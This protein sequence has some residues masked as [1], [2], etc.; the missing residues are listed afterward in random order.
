VTLAWRVTLTVFAVAEF[1]A[2]MTNDLV[3]QP[4]IWRF[5]AGAL[6]FCLSVAA[7]I[8]TL[9]GPF[10]V[11]FL[12]VRRQWPP[13]ASFTLS[14]TADGPAFVVP[15]SPMFRG[16]GAM[17]MVSV[18]SHQVA[19]DR[20]SEVGGL[21]Y[22]TTS[23]IPMIV[24]LAYLLAAFALAYLW[25][26]ITPV[27]LT[28]AGVRLRSSSRSRLTPWDD[29]LDPTGRTERLRLALRTHHVDRFLAA[30]IR[31]YA[32]H[33]EHR[34]DIGTRSELDRLRSLHRTRLP[35]AAGR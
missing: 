5:D 18:S 30:V 28:P 1:A 13:L 34:A 15:E 24:P 16:L 11:F 22:S 4:L 33:P 14:T 23:W 35:T 26:P 12:L 31:H 3:L 27:T 7:F 32:E 21:R 6:G 8:T 9:A 17:L 2:V 10:L 20:V 19:M 29:V 25:L